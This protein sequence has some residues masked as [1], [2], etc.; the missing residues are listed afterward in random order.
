MH[1]LN[2][3]IKL[4]QPIILSEKSGDQNIVETKSYIPG[5]TLN[6]VFSHLY[7][8]KEKADDNFYRLFLRNDVQFHNSYLL[9]N[10]TPSFPIPLS[11]HTE[12]YDDSKAY[13]L[14]ILASLPIET[15]G[16][17]GTGYFDK[18]KLIKESV[19]TT[20]NFHHRRNYEKGVS[21]EGKIFNYNSISQDQVF[22]GSITGEKKD[23]EI[24]ENII[25]NNPINRLGRSKTSQYG[26]VEIESMGIK[27]LEIPKPC[28]VRNGVIMTFLSDTIIY[29]N[30]GF[31]TS[32]TY[33]IENILGVRI[34][35][36]FMKR[37]KA[38]NFVTIKKQKNPSEVTIVAGS[39]F[40]L[41]KLPENYKNIETNGLG[42]RT[43]EGFGRISFGIQHHDSYS[44]TKPE[45]SKASNPEYSAL[46][47]KIFISSI[48]KEIEEIIIL[49]SLEHADEFSKNKAIPTSL[50]GRLTLASKNAKSFEVFLEKISNLRR[51]ALNSLEDCLNKQNQ[52]L[53]QFFNSLD[54]SI[55]Y[56][57]KLKNNFR[58]ELLASINRSD[59]S[60]LYLKHFL[61]QMRRNNKQKK[62]QEVNHAR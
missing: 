60:K 12:K 48:I 47:I 41:E 36:Q 43:N 22:W 44:V 10:N 56:E 20:L 2:F 59:L 28:P 33:D 6:G 49:K 19:T 32:D 57:A 35:N 23:L 52:N 29:N 58:T 27:Q 62:G 31:S 24:I 34:I 53:L 18:S 4:L 54:V 42:M 46:F 38:E 16:I 25:N 50:I 30:Y 40:L 7:L 39:C 45:T 15:K 8:K 14:L 9:V 61:N 5:T 21:D 11:V 26:K 51:K 37:G 1:I 3:T 17:S 13:D 55:Y